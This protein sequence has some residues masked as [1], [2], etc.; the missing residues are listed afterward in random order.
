MSPRLRYPLAVALLCAATLCAGQ[1]IPVPV[2]RWLRGP[3][4]RDFPWKVRLLPPRLTFQQRYLLQVRANLPVDVLQQGS[5]QRDLHFAVRVA[6][7]RGHWFPGGDYTHYAVPPKL[8]AGNEIEYTT[9]VYLR[10]GKYLLAVFAYD[11]V[12]GQGNLRRRMLRVS[13]LKHDPL[14]QLDRDLPAVE[15][16]RDVRVSAAEPAGAMDAWRLAEG[17]EWLPVR[18]SRP[19]RVDIVVNFSAWLDPQLRSAVSGLAYPRHV[20]HLLEIGSVLSHLD[21]ARGCVRLSGVDINNARIVFDRADA[22]GFDWEAARK[23]ILSTNQDLVD[24]AALAQRPGTALFF[25]R[26]LSEV[27]YNSGGCGGD[28]AHV[29]RVV[30][31]AGGSHLFP[32]ETRLFGVWPEMPCDCQFYYL[33]ASTSPGDDD[34]DHLLKRVAPRRLRFDTG[35]Q[36]R[37]ALAR[38]I[39]DLEAEPR[40]GLRDWSDAR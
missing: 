33:R 6:D 31:I 11:S 17:R 13:P 18:D 1:A 22:A 15:F 30:I 8:D 20:G 9:G 14:P 2:E 39:A 10:P 38:I 7:E 27:L 3:D 16:L 19:L 37:R 26:F 5:A 25:R 28:H 32:A 29:R 35:E 40:G 36:F 23:A 24:V 4:R 21:L 34:I 12:T